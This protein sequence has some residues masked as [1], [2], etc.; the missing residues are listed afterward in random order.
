MAVV[1]HTFLDK[2]NTII[3]GSDTNLGLNPILEMYYGM[4]YSRG[5]IHFDVSKLKRLVDDKT[6]PDISKLTHRLKM[7]N[8]AGLRTQYQHKFNKYNNAKRAKSFNLNFFLLEQPW[9][10]GGGFDYKRDGY[11]ALNTIHS[12]DGSNWYKADNLTLWAHDGVFNYDKIAENAIA[13]QHFDVGNESVLVF[14]LRDFLYKFLVL[15]VFR[16]FCISLFRVAK[17]QNYLR[18]TKYDLRF[19]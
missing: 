1:T 18:L 6:Y 13:T 14:R 15:C 12:T 16:H 5:L 19:N 8:V 4:P 9:D 2:T 11:E 10:M 7:Q 3:Y 17:I